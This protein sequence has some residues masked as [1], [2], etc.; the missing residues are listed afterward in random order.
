VI[1]ILRALGRMGDA[2]A[3]GPLAERASG[4]SLFS[5]VP[6]PI[7]VEATRAL[8]DIG[9]EAARIVLQRLMRDRNDAIR[10]TALKA[11]EGTAGEA[12]LPGE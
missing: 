8:G 9:G 4:G 11:S 12:A 5:R 1:E 2:R 6:L 3:V 10:E 7:R